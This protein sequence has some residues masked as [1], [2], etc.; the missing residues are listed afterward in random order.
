MYGHTLYTYKNATDSYFFA[1]K[2]I[3]NADEL[4]IIK[5]YYN[6]SLFQGVEPSQ[7][8]FLLSIIGI[9]NTFGR[10]ACGWVADFPWVDSLLLN[11][12]CLI[13]A[14]VSCM[15]TLHMKQIN[16]PVCG[17]AGNL[18]TIRTSTG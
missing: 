14:T 13:I 17:L 5:L 4:I 6:F 11:N 1:L 3:L 12:I 18:N 2:H 8:S 15:V 7:A 16:Y 10:I 9:T